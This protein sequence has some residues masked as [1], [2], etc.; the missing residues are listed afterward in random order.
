[1][2]LPTTRVGVPVL[3]LA[4]KSET[5]FLDRS[6]FQSLNKIRNCMTDDIAFR[7][8]GS[9]ILKNKSRTHDLKYPMIARNS[10]PNLI[11]NKG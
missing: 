11:P 8:S 5:E 4:Q 6:P 1:M 7:G 9:L 2:K 3:N 10:L